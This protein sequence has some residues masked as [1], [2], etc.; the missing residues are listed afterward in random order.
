MKLTFNLIVFV[1]AISADDD[2]CD[3]V[4]KDACSDDM[5]LEEIVTST[6]L[7]NKEKERKEEPEKV[8][9]EKERIASPVDKSAT[10]NLNAWLKAF[11]APKKPKKSEEEELKKDEKNETHSM[12][13][14]TSPTVATEQNFTLP[15]PRT[16]KASTGS[17]ISER[18]SFSQDPD[19]PRIG[20]DE[21]ICGSYPAPYPSPLG[22]SPI[23]TSPKDDVQKPSSPYPPM[24]GAIR[25]GFYQDTTTKS[26]PEKS[27]SPR[28]QPSASPYSNYAQ[29]L[30]I[31]TTSTA[32][33]T[34]T[35]LAYTSPPKV[36]S[37]TS[38]GFNNKNKPT[39]PASN[40]SMSRRQHQPCS[41]LGDQSQDS[42]YNSSVGSNPN[43]PYQN[44][45]S[46]YQADNSPYQQ[47]QTS[48]YTQTSIS[49]PSQPL[50]SNSPSSPY[51]A[52]ASPYQN[53]QPLSPYNDS[54]NQTARSQST[55]HQPAQAQETSQPTAGYHSNPTSP[56]SQQKPTSPYNQQPQHISQ[57]TNLPKSSPQQI[58]H[59]SQQPPE[60]K[61]VHNVPEPMQHLQHQQS[62]VSQTQHVV[63][64]QSH[65]M[66]TGL[67]NYM[68]Y[69]SEAYAQP[70]Y[71]NLGESSAPINSMINDPNRA[72]QMGQALN[73]VLPPK[74]DVSNQNVEPSRDILNLDYV[75]TSSASKSA[76][77]K[78]YDKQMD[79]SEM[80]AR[81]D[82]NKPDQ[83]YDH[84]YNTLAFNKNMGFNKNFDISSTKAI[85][86]FNRAATMSFSK[87]FPST[88]P[89]N[90]KND[91]PELTNLTKV[92]PGMLNPYQHLVHSNYPKSTAPPELIN[93]GYPMDNKAPSH[94]YNQHEIEKQQQQQSQHKSN[95]PP[96]SLKPNMYDQQPMPNYPNSLPVPHAKPVDQRYDMA[97]YNRPMMEENM[98]GLQPPPASYYQK[99]LTTPNL[100][101]ANV[102]P[103]QPSAVSNLQMLKPPS[104][105]GTSRDHQNHLHDYQRVPEP[106][107]QSALMQNQIVPSTSSAAPIQPE[108]KPKRTRKKKNAEP[109]PS[110]ALAPIQND[111]IPS[112]QLQHQLQH[113]SIDP[114]AQLNQQQGFQSY[115]GLKPNSAKNA[116][117][118]ESTAIS[119][120]TSSSIVPGSAF[121]F[122]PTTSG[123][124]LGTGMY[125]DSTPYPPNP[126]YLPQTHH[127]DQTNDVS[128]Q[129][130]PDPIHLKKHPDIAT[131]SAAA[132]PPPPASTYH[133]F[134]PHPPSRS[135]YP[136]FMNPP[137]DTN[138]QFYQQYE[139]YRQARFMLNH[140]PGYA[141]SSY[142]SALGMQAINRP[143]WFQ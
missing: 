83:G 4:S 118:S 125:G 21:R 134:L 40:M 128:C 102:I 44:Q 41:Y 139:E 20:I 116:P 97:N 55:F 86:M 112:Q 103:A 85:E 6:E 119:L 132:L 48:P 76:V 81:K 65:S 124:G 68:G 136:P 63:Q 79:P 3:T 111:L 22:A 89:P 50:N 117:P 90:A 58:A 14:V 114:Q 95:I 130:P 108:P 78:P 62:Q 32:A 69:P 49:T 30:Y 104:A 88:L 16:R 18:S 70:H 93:M 5:E 28:E 113:H 106:P 24:N 115:A 53:Q 36:A 37:T 8:T 15:A 13:N 122:G 45:Q 66:S 71:T 51:A 135:T 123:L 141:Q 67:H 143:P 127:A 27:C 60:N 59:M 52:P 56:Y 91:G 23:M 98:N 82:I 138:A 10:P 105:Y 42:D 73:K 129:R 100:Y 96:A 7:M 109:P 46:P 107:N 80:D 12:T 47:P 25:V 140:M 131:A 133:Q 38:L 9:V 11:G 142:H 74:H 35:N 1:I 77:N 84:M 64:Q 72:L 2:N 75:K 110:A 99:D 43:S 26:S 19:S 29:H 39:S 57:M 31:S 54:N 92:S 120:K 17:T 87:T 121:N 61:S 33:P 101:G 126:Y 34:Y 94:L 137:L